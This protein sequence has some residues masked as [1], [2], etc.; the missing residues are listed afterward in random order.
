MTTRKVQ[1][2]PFGLDRNV[3]K[4]PERSAAQG[5]RDSKIPEACPVDRYAF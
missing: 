2:L 5:L 3:A 4:K 1:R